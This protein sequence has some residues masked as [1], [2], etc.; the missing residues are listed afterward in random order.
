MAVP[1]SVGTLATGY[2]VG[3]WLVGSSW[4]ALTQFD[5]ATNLRLRMKKATD[6]SSSWSTV[7]SGTN[8]PVSQ[9]SGKA[10]L[11]EGV[12]VVIGTRIYVAFRHSSDALNVKIFDTT[13]DTWNAGAG[14]TVE[15]SGNW[16]PGGAAGYIGIATNGAGDLGVASTLTNGGIGMRRVPAATLPT[17]AFGPSLGLMSSGA[18]PYGP[19]RVVGG[20]ST[21]WHV[22]GSYGGAWHFNTVKADF[23]VATTASSAPTLGSSMAAR[24]MQSVN[25]GGTWKIVVLG[26]D[27]TTGLRWGYGDSADALTNLTVAS[28]AASFDAADAVRHL[29]YLDSSWRFTYNRTSGGPA[30]RTITDT[31]TSLGTA[32][33][34]RPTTGSHTNPGTLAKVT[35][36]AHDYYGVVDGGN[37]DHFDTSPGSSLSRSLADTITIADTAVRS[38]LARARALADTITIADTL[39][40]TVTE[41]RSLAD[42]LTIGDALAR[43]A[44]GQSRTAGDTLT[45]TDAVDASSIASLTRDI[46]DTITIGDAVAR[47]VSLGRGVADSVTIGDSL[48]R[49]AISFVRA[50][51]DTIT[52]TDSLARQ[53]ST[54]A[55]VRTVTRYSATTRPVGQHGAGTRAVGQHR[56]G[57]NP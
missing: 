55:Q 3:P 44:V 42:T 47:A 7:G 48:A 11:G 2:D 26:D 45:I 56:S 34:F 41:A 53:V 13:T 49:S 17:L 36:T 52:I 5:D 46:A 20:A 19:V 39:A 12:G 1:T 28:I 21:R 50:I 15:N 4:Y 18:I 31:G 40:R 54:T 37:Y 27:G 10:S 43:S 24:N 35:L 6:P 9:A 30:I 32:A 22:A 25:V 51:A 38:S 57:V 33:T 14:T 16:S 8:E 23:T 29:G